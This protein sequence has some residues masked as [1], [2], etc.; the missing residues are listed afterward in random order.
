MRTKRL[1]RVSVAAQAAFLWSG[2]TTLQESLQGLERI[3]TRAG[4]RFLLALLCLLYSYHSVVT[5]DGARKDC[6]GERA[7]INSLD[8]MERATCCSA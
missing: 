2:Q 5:S 6:V 3:A 7:R 4:I 1:L 8:F